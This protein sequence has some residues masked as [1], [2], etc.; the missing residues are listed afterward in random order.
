MKAT[1]IVRKID[2]LGRLVIPAEIVKMQEFEPN[3]LVQFFVEGK[4]IIIS[5][6]Q[7]SC[8]F[9]DVDNLNMLETFNGKLV[10]RECIG[11]IKK[12]L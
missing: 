1:G 6:Y 4:N 2:D 10:C 12:I 3:Q 9:C 11:L 5:K 8:T 7:K